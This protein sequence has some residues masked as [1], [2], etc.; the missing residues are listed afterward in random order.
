MP[1]RKQDCPKRMKWEGEGEGSPDDNEKVDADDESGTMTPNSAASPAPGGDEASS[2]PPGALLSPKSTH[3]VGNES[4]HQALEKDQTSPRCNSHESAES[5]IPPRC[6]SDE[7]L[8][9]DRGDLR[10]LSLSGTSLSPI[11]V[12]LPPTL[13]VAAAAALLPPQS[14]AM[15]AYLNAAAAAA[16]HSHRLM[17]TS[18]LPSYNRVSAS[19]LISSS[20]PP[21]G[22]NLPSTS[23]IPDTL[24]SLSSAGILDFSK[25]TLKN[26]SDDSDAN[27]MNLSKV[28]AMPSSEPHFNSPL[29]LSVTNRKRG[30]E[31]IESQPSLRK[32]RTADYK[33]P[34]LSQWA[35]PIAAPH[36]PYFAAAVA[37]ANLSPKTNAI[38][39]AW[40]GKLKYGAA[41]PSDATKALEKMSELSKLGGEDLFRSI[42]NTGVSVNSNSRH[43]A[44]QSHWLNKGAEQAKDVLKCVWCKQSF[45][46]LAA[47][48]THMKEA[49][50]CGVNVPVS[51][52]QSQN[53][54]PQPPISSPSSNASSG[55]SS[56]SS[57]NKP[58]QSDLN[59]LIKETMPL[60][61]KLVRG[62]DVWLGKGAEQTRQILKCMWCGQSFRSLAEM[63]SH[64]QQTQ[65]YTN[66]ISQEQII[67]W[68]SSDD[69]KGGGGPG[70][71]N[72]SSGSAGSANSHVSAV[73]TCKVC[74]QAFS[75]LKELS[76][77]MVKNSHYK[78]HIMRSITDGGRRRQTREK[79]KKSLPVRKLLELERAQHEFKNGDT[80]SILGKASSAGRITC[81]KCGDKID[82]S[83]FVDHIRQCVGGG[84]LGSSQR[85]FLKSALLSNSILPPENLLDSG[86]NVN[87]ENGKNNESPSTPIHQSPN[88]VTSG[89]RS[90]TP[91]NNNG[92]SP[93]V[94][95]AIEKLIEK[96]FDSRTRQNSSYASHG[97]ATAPMGSSIL[98]R[99]GIDESVDYTKPLVDAQTMNLLRSYH[100]QQ[101]HHYSKRERSGSESSSISERGSRVDAL[102]PERKVESSSHHPITSTPR[103]TPDKRDKSPCSEKTSYEN[104]SDGEISIKKELEDG[105]EEKS[106]N[107][108]V[109]R[110]VPDS[111]DDFERSTFNN[112]RTSKRHADIKEDLDGDQKKI[113]D[114]LRGSPVSSPQ[115]QSMS[116]DVGNVNS[117]CRNSTCSPA[118]S[119]RSTTPR[120]TN[121]DKKGNNS[122]GALSSMF[123]NLSGAST[124]A[125]SA[126][127]SGKRTS[128][129]PLAALQK[130][131]D[132]TETHHTNRNNASASAP[133]SIAVATSHNVTQSGG[134]TPGAILAFS[135]ACN[136]AVMTSDSIMKCPF[137]DS[138]FISKGAYRHHLSKMHFVKD[139]VIPDPV[140]L[141][142]PQPSSSSGPINMKGGNGSGSGSSSGITPTGNKSP[143]IS[144][145]FE[146]SPHSKFLKYTELA[147]QLSSKYV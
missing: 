66:I 44:W 63:T 79:R 88:D 54:P 73:L 136:D 115:R 113:S 5:S 77:H 110:E 108:C 15:A 43:S 122:L 53:L 62:Q 50:H 116:A 83:L 129:H 24:T 80:A 72:A 61:R 101:S 58:N 145:N 147:K 16:Q 144:G 120:S 64:M 68:K 111:S 70:N 36:L 30:S 102:T 117:P 1:R 52:V 49:K 33:S 12:A 29:D 40:N 127:T 57:S 23:P 38:T 128:S 85:N 103:S 87:R 76:N 17:M 98:K 121:G 86:S 118:S 3:S 26:D 34:L 146:E 133:P 135:W 32:Q 90:S 143:P 7:S 100:Q 60:P 97:P 11:G 123:D 125:D 126:N 69:S 45:P 138:P 106:Q 95:N 89:K 31:E 114:G 55:V 37:A 10:G 96:S 9:S 39:D 46:S 109:K 139:G 41:T 91:E 27:V 78:E 20:S 119:D 59:L 67:S 56:T 92:S 94:L 132:K 18:P 112:V 35:S 19:P 48:T 124:S 107:V 2:P 134:P 131:C 105:D 22:M 28:D 71:G 25:R 82:T 21:S 4:N 65:H 47:M 13:P 137:C 130:L 93:S 141:K 140:V 14:A 84:A 8:Y 51:S 99:L 104:K 74:D 81:E 75:S 142:S 42:A 6:L